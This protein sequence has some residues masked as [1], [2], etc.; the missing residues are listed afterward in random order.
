VP[1]EE[2]PR[3]WS[4]DPVYPRHQRRRPYTPCT[5]Q[6]AELRA[7]RDRTVRRKRRSALRARA[8]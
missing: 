4:V 8:S 7:G 3:R 1:K 5:S 2:R 6:S